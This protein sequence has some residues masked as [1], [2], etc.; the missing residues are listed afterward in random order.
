MKSNHMYKM[1]INTHIHTHR[2]VHEFETIMYLFAFICVLRCVYP[3]VY[4]YLYNVTYLSI[5][6]TKVNNIF[7][8]LIRCFS[9]KCMDACAHTHIPFM[10]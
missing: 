4:T 8:K 1:Y 10:N 9:L 3:F 7:N 2:L 6:G 5:P